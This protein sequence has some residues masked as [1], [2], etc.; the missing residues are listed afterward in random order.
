MKYYY[1]NTCLTS[2]LIVNECLQH[3]IWDGNCSA[4]FRLRE[5][6][7]DDIKSITSLWFVI[8]NVNLKGCCGTS[9]TYLNGFEA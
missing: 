4:Y 5:K 2:K 9:D 1:N 7:L 6:L 3:L 8:T